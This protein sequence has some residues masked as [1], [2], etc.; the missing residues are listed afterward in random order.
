MNLIAKWRKKASSNVLLNS[1]IVISSILS[2]CVLSHLFMPIDIDNLGGAHSWLSGSTV[3]FVNNWLKDGAINDKFT[4]YEI[5]DSIENSA[6]E[7]RSPYLSYPTGE[8]FFVYSAAKML[9]KEEISVSFVHVF[10]LILFCLGGVLFA[11]FVNAFL[12]RTVGYKKFFGRYVISIATASLWVC[13]PTCCYYLSN[14]FFADQC[15][16]FWVMLF[17][18]IEY[19]WITL[20]NKKYKIPILIA[21]AIVLYA[22]VMTDYYFWILAFCC[23]VMEAILNYFGCEKS[24]R[25]ISRVAIKSLSLVI[26]VVMAVVTFIIQISFTPNCFGI[27]K[28]RFTQ[29]VGG[30]D[31][32]PFESYRLILSNFIHAFTPGG[33]MAIYLIFIVLAVIVGCIVAVV[34]G[35]KAKKVLLNPG[36][37]LVIFNTLAIVLQL[38][39]LKNHS[40]IH[41]FSMLKV[42]WFIA[43]LPLILTILILNKYHLSNSKMVDIFIGCFVLILLATGLPSSSRG[44]FNERY[45]YDA[46][47]VE[48]ALRSQIGYEDVLFSFTYEAPINPPQ[49]QA[50]IGKRVYKIDELK[51]MNELF[52]NLDGNAQRVIVIEKN[53]TLEPG[54]K[55]I[56]K[57]LEQKYGIRY[58]DDNIK[59]INVSN[60]I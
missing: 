34:R 20:K 49:Q 41:E 15:I 11:L 59:L 26:P 22:G 35:K 40:A 38:F 27:L 2:F 10:Q 23:F 8:T 32:S 24:E 45:S 14:I 3:I 30:N 5:Y 28:G 25:K 37:S 4:T 48:Y 57:E 21:R 58:E 53:K 7:E 36:I 55:K 42:A 19:Y 56:C 29:R 54:Q 13:L 9:G 50:I 33:K 52:P 46:H 47:V 12:D 16:I 43:L 1:L 6:P 31:E 39:F 51:N 44:F 60:D 18:L 17:I